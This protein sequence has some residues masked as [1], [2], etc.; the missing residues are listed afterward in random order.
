M[1]IATEIQRLQ[2]AKANIKTAI[3][4]K[5]VI[6]GDGTIDI[7]AEKIGEILGGGSVVDLS[8][9]CK[10]IQFES[11][12]VFGKSEVVLDLEN[13]TIINSIF[14]IATNAPLLQN[15]TVEHITINCK[16][17]I[18]DIYRAFYCYYNI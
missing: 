8:K 4:N 14:A 7:Y 13:C 3:E 12:N 18:T 9:L 1:S 11:L 2:T 15:T 16:K 17:P 5:G 6:V 10:Q